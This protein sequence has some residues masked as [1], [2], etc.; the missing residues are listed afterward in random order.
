MHTENQ[1]SEESEE[2][3]SGTESSEMADPKVP[4]HRASWGNDDSTPT[5]VPNKYAQ[6]QTREKAP[7]QPRDDKT[8]LAAA[9]NDDET[10]QSVDVDPSSSS[11]SHRSASVFSSVLTSPAHDSANI[12]FPRRKQ[13]QQREQGRKGIAVTMEIL[14]TVFHMP[15]H[16]ACKKLGVCA[17]ALKRACR[18]LGVHKWP[19][20]DLHGSREQRST[21]P[22]QEERAEENAS[23][24]LSE[25]SAG[26][27]SGRALDCIPRHPIAEAPP[28]WAPAVLTILP[29]EEL[30]VS[31][32][33]QEDF[34]CLKLPCPEEGALEDAYAS[35]GLPFPG[36]LSTEEWQAEAKDGGARTVSMSTGLLE[37]AP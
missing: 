6:A 31:A 23:G 4:L 35:W 17:T 24:E 30:L 26:M 13:G 15:L 10:S 5:L 3:S 8:Q 16:K 36:F 32:S 21:G 14:E 22:S 18:K 28:C 33:R 27:T 20:R 29:D 19:Y 37:L 1:S 2:C 12:I 34:G 11:F 25:N 7:H 9:A